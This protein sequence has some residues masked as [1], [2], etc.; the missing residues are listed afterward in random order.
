MPIR[1]RPTA[2]RKP[3]DDERQRGR[4]HD[5]GPQLPLRCSG[6]RGRPRSSLRIDV[7]H[8]LIGVDHHREEREQEQDDHLRD[9]LEAGPQHDERHERDRRNRIEEGDVDAERDVE[10]P[11]AREQQADRDADHGREREAE[12]R[13]RRGSATD[14]STIRRCRSSS[15]AARAIALGVVNSTGSTR[16]PKYLPE[17]QHDRERDEADRR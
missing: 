8:P 2:S 11:E 13:A 4:Q 12:R 1:P 10:H 15:T 3:G 7:L 6:R 17:R 9:R 16:A 14:R 5:V